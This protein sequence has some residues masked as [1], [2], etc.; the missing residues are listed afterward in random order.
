MNQ[1]DDSRADR[2]RE[3]E[4][5]LLAANAAIEGRDRDGLRRCVEDYL[6]PN[7]EWLPHIV[8]VE[9]AV[10]RGLDGLLAWFDDLTAS[11]DIR[12]IKPEFRW[13]SDDTMVYLV[14]LELHGRE[15]SADVSQPVGVVYELEDEL[16][17]RGKVYPSHAEAVAAAEALHA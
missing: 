3:A 1:S 16:L 17:R 7:Y 8:G 10:Y 15:S 9:G 6:H 4:E 12:Y 11:F 2:M 13:P 14:T 5:R